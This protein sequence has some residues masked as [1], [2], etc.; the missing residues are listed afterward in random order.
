MSGSI[1]LPA[2]E[3]EWL[4]RGALA[5]A[6]KDDV[7]PALR[8]DTRWLRSGIGALRFVL[9]TAAEKGKFQPVLV[10]NTEGTARG[11]VQPNLLLDARGYGA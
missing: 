1:A 7:T 5:A 10:V 6:S 9:P 4:L 2:H 11:L 8:A 3:A